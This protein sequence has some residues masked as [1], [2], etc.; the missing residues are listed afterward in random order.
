MYLGGMY[1][2]IFLSK[3]CIIEFIQYN[4]ILLKI[5]LNYFGSWIRRG[6]HLF[7]Q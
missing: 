4:T 1:Q 7:V 3:E 5:P 6:F 2:V